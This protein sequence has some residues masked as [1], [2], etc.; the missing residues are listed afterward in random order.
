MGVYIN[1]AIIAI[2]FN[3]YT[4]ASMYNNMDPHKRKPIFPWPI[5]QDYPFKYTHVYLVNLYK[6]YPSVIS[7]M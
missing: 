7:Q 4:A 1:S 2:T 6:L 3:N 5:K